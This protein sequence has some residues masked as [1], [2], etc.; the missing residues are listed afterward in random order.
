MED[1]VFTSLQ[2][3]EILGQHLVD[4]GKIPAGKYTGFIDI[5]TIKNRED[6]ILTLTM[7]RK[8]ND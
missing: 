4:E 2:V 5:E 1:H 8:G 3:R 6:F 7:K